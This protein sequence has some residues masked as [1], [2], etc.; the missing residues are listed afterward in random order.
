MVGTGIEL[1]LVSDCQGLVTEISEQ[2]GG[3]RGQGFHGEARGQCSGK[4]DERAL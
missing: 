2:K 3:I 4:E 1:P